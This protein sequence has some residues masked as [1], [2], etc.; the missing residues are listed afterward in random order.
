MPLGAPFDLGQSR[1][2]RFIARRSSETVDRFRGKDDQAPFGKRLDRA[3]DYISR[4]LFAANI[5]D[6]G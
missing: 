2:G 5:D 3:M 6:R 1:D 4:I